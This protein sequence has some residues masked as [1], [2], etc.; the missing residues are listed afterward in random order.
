MLEKLTS[1][2]NNIRETNVDTINPALRRKHT[3]KMRQ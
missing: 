3:I 1:Q 2:K